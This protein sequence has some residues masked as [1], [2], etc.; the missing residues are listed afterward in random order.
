MKVE[1]RL[2][3]E[4]VDRI[5]LDELTSEYAVINQ[6]PTATELA[7]SMR[8]VIEYYEANCTDVTKNVSKEEPEPVQESYLYG[9]FTA[10]SDINIKT[11]S[12]T[13]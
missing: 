7:E 6:M 1:L 10:I 13:N 4:D 3:Q 9:N 12:L 8:V 11:T 2:H 5:V